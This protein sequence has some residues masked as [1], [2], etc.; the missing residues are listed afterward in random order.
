MKFSLE[1]LQKITNFFVPLLN[2]IKLIFLLPNLL[3][4]QH[5]FS[6]YL[7]GTIYRS[8]KLFDEI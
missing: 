5:M 2:N 6:Y 3:L 8:L 4:Q 1:K 7:A